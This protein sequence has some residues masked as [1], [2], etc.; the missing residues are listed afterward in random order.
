[1]KT[2]M[3]D[4][5]KINLS[6]DFGIFVRYLRTR[7][8]HFMVEGFP[9]YEKI[10]TF[11][12]NNAYYIPVEVGNCFYRAR[13]CTPDDCNTL[14]LQDRYVINGIFD[15][16]REPPQM[17]KI[18]DPFAGFPKDQ[19]GAPPARMCGEGRANG[20]GIKR[21]Y[22]AKNAYTAVAETKPSLGSVVSIAT[23]KNQYRFRV[24]NLIDTIADEEA[25]FLRNLINWQFSL[26]CSG[27]SESYSF[28]QWFGDLVERYGYRIGNHLEGDFGRG[29]KY[30]SAVHDGGENLV[31]FGRHMDNRAGHP[32][33]FKEYS[34]E[35]Y[36]GFEAI[37]SEIC[38]IKDVAYDL[39]HL[40]PE[41]AV[42]I[43]LGKTN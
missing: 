14:K 36:F 23:Q 4:T 12:V 16:R 22:I 2:I 38:Y 33:G 40:M 3:D 6:C 31:V 32:L 10:L 7:N 8:R 34:S 13:I 42:N 15:T 11:V 24:L 37:G 35:E 27:D 26:A 25:D 29:I 20:K 17:D 1:M 39:K 30:S 18:D 5:S 28:T 9:I 19:C 43:E 21:L 41:R